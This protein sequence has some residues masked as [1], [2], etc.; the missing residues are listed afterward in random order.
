MSNK[1]LSKDQRR[2]RA[3]LLARVEQ[4]ESALAVAHKGARESRKRADDA[5]AKLRGIEAQKAY[6][7]LPAFDDG[8]TG[9]PK[10]LSAH[11]QAKVTL[12]LSSLAHL[13]GTG[14]EIL[15]GWIASWSSI[16]VRPM[17]RPILPP[18]HLAYTCRCG[19]QWRTKAAD[20]EAV[21]S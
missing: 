3:R 18:E 11:D 6:D 12:T 4:Q 17:P 1:G 15:D 20:A 21:S 10:C 19:Y 14:A 9:C 7:A 13:T 16:P 8:P 2:D 5:E